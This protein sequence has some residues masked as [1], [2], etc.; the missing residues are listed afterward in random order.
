VSRIAIRRT[1]KLSLSRAKRVAT[2]VA[3][4][5]QEEY[6]IRSHWEASALYFTGSGL[7]GCLRLSARTVSIDVELGFLMATFRDTICAAIEH[8]LDHELAARPDLKVSRAKKAS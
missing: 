6:G 3:A 1:H 7:T 2:A 8:K 4:Q 5:L